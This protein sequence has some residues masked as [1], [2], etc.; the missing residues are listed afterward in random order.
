[1]KSSAVRLAALAL[2]LAVIGGRAAWAQATVVWTVDP[3]ESSA[4][5]TATHL[6]ISHVSGTIP[7]V[8][9]SL[10]IPQGSNI[11]TS[12]QGRLDPS[13][14]DTHN[15]RR[16]ND[17]RSPHFLDVA[18]YPEMTFTSTSIKATDAKNF[19]VSG[20]LTMHGV[21]KPLTLNAQF[22]GQGPGMKAGEKRVGYVADGTI[23]RSQWGMTSGS[24]M[25]GNDIAI[26]LEVAAYNRQ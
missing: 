6:L 2:T 9:G 11:P 20:T 17:L 5:F 7:I 13:K 21:T 16:D 23:D 19:V 1:M 24:P 4:A 25:V 12:V 15:D 10:V 26:H 18:N 22:L 8:S 3:V 14:V